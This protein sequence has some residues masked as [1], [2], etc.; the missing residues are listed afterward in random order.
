MD[1][2][3]DSQV[4]EPSD[5]CDGDVALDSLLP[6]EAARAID[7]C[8][9]AAD[10]KDWGL[11]SAQWVLPDGAGPA[12]EIVEQKLH[13]GHG[14]LPD[15]GPNVLPHAGT[16]L[17]ALSTGTARRPADP[18]YEVPEFSSKGYG[19]GV[20]PGFPKEEPACMGSMSGPPYDGVALEVVVR[21]P[22]NAHGFSF[23]LDFY[24]H[25]WPQ[26][27]CSSYN[28]VFFALL[29]PAP[30]G[31]ADGHIA[32]DQKGNPLTLNSADYRVCGCAAGPPCSAGGKS[33]D[34]PLGV[35]QLLGTGF[36]DNG[37]GPRAATGWLTVSA[38]ADPGTLITLRWGA[39]DADD[40]LGTTTVL[41]DNWKWITSPGVMV[42]T[43]T[44]R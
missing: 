9:V 28:D 14:I 4:D 44:S 16:Q 13:M 20:V 34:C 18:G 3:C 23:D 5:T 25:D 36:E 37:M 6:E 27:L 32:Y 21:A 35:D 40:G 31:G 19:H 38:P 17:L 43:T 2:D 22:Q 30:L 26:Y 42:G 29:S 39:Y 12:D 41:V 7:L 15:F 33:F 11:V 24:A 1:E 10:E 8:K